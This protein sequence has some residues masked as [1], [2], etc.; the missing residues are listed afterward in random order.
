MGIDRA[1]VTTSGGV[2]KVSSDF[3]PMQ[4]RTVQLLSSS[5]EGPRKGRGNNSNH[6]TSGRFD[7]I[8][9]SIRRDSEPWCFRVAPF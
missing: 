5:G 1:G 7:R 4:S 2:C 3:F 9:R 6:A 8:D